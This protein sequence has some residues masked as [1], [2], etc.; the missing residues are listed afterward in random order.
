MRGTPCIPD[1][2]RTPP[3]RGFKVRVTMCGCGQSAGKAD[4]K[5]GTLRDCTPGSRVVRLSRSYLL[6][7]MHDGTVRARTLRISQREESYV[8]LLQQLVLASGGRAWTY[9]EGRTR[10]LYVVEFSR[11][12]LGSHRPR[13][14]RDLIDYV[15]GY[16]DA[17]GG[18]PS[19]PAKPP[20]LYFAQKDRRDLEGVRRIL[21]SI[22]IACG[23]IHN[24][25]RRVDPDYWRF[26]V[27]R[28]SLRRFAKVVGSWHP[29]KAVL[30]RMMIQS[31]PHGDMGST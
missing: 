6:G 11:S 4:R 26:Y 30:L 1:Y 7:A 12:F 20:Y 17:E 5:I 22:G 29:R 18:I 27:S 13:T 25:S 19:D 2:F 9:R 24:P 21:L 10:Q 31:T 15:R 3:A 28:R 16:F 14:R 23:R 8:L